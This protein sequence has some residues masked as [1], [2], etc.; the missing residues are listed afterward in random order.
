MKMMCIKDEFDFIK[1]GQVYEVGAAA[2][3][4]LVAEFRP[5]M[6]ALF[7]KYQFIPLCSL[8]RILWAESDV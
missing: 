6:W 5:G 1:V 2:N 8:G 4:C 3:G 7:W